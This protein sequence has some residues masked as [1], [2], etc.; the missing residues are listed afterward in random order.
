MLRTY[1]TNKYYNRHNTLEFIGDA[2]Y[3]VL[4]MRNYEN[5]EYILYLVSDIKG[6]TLISLSIPA[7]KGVYYA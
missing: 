5:K 3:K 7:Y 4:L 6:N 2:T 1:I